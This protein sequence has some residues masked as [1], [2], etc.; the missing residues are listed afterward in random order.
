M[1]SSGRS[2]R[3]G[4]GGKG[5]G[6]KGQGGRGQGEEG[7]GSKR[8]SPANYIQGEGEEGRPAEKERAR[9][10]L[11]GRMLLYGKSLSLKKEENKRKYGR[12]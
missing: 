3:E 6:G 8:R 7:E 1:W 4:Q 9:E 10:S 12:C 2:R 5:Q 11:A